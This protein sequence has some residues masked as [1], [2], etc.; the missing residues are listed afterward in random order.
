MTLAVIRV[1]AERTH[2]LRRKVL[3]AERP[4]V[5]VV[6]PIDADPETV[7]FAIAE[8]ESEPSALL[9]VSTW[10]S[11]LSPAGPAGPGMQLRGM[12]VDPNHRGRGLGHLLVAAGLA[13]ARER[14]AVVAWANARDSAL[15]FYEHEGF[16]VVGDGFLTADTG[17]PHHVILYRLHPEK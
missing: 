2:D 16:S 10:G 6:F 8:R 5:S 7:H 12:A 14:G 13:L 3:R 1:T 9:G 4:E 15:G 17:L 11:A